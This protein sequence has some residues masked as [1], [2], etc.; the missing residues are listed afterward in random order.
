MLS[1]FLVIIIVIAL[2]FTE[3]SDLLTLSFETISAFGTVGLTRGITPHLS[4]SRK[5]C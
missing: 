5:K 1:A 2:S 4:L 3:Q